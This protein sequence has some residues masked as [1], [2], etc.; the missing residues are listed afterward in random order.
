MDQHKMR[1]RDKNNGTK[2]KQS[3]IVLNY[4]IQGGKT[5]DAVLA[6]VLD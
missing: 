4:I 5:H 6:S 1:K 3:H 2:K